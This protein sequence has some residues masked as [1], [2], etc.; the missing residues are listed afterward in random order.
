ME[1][2]E[3]SSIPFRIGETVEVIHGVTEQNHQVFWVGRITD[4]HFD[5][6]NHCF[7]YFVQFSLS[8]GGWYTAPD[9]KKVR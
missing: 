8:E 1:L 2:K 6:N 5:H 7:E 4:S 9:L 3:V